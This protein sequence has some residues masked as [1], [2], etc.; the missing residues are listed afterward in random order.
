MTSGKSTNEALL[1]YFSLFV[2]TTD[3][4]GHSLLVDA[5]TGMVYQG[6][7]AQ[8]PNIKSLV[9]TIWLDNN[10][11][12][13]TFF[14][15]WKSV[16]SRSQD[17]VFQLHV[18]QYMSAYTGTPGIVSVDC[19]SFDF[20]S[21]YVHFR[22]VKG[23]SQSQA[24]ERVIAY[25]NSGIALDDVAVRD[26][27]SLLLN[28][29][30]DC[31]QLT[32][33]KEINCLLAIKSG[34]VPKNTE[35][36]LRCIIYSATDSTLLIKS[37]EV[38]DQLKKFDASAWFD[39]YEKR[40][41]LR[42]LAESFNRFKPL[43]L[44]LK[45]PSTAKVIN[46]ISKLS[47][48]LHRPLLAN[49]MN[50]VTTQL[51]STDTIWVKD[52]STFALLRSLDALHR[53]KFHPQYGAYRIRNGK[54]FAKEIV[55]SQKD[56]A[57]LAANYQII[58]H[59]LKSRIGERND[60]VYIPSNVD[61]AVPVSQKSF[62]GNVPSLTR[63]STSELQVGIYWENCM[64]ARDLDLSS[65][66]I[67][68]SKIGWDG[69]YYNDLVA[70]SGDITNA[71]DGAVEYLRFLPGAAS[72]YLVN[73][74]VYS[75]SPTSGYNLI[76][77]DNSMHGDLKS[78]TNYEYMMDPKNLVFSSAQTAYNNSNVLGYVDLSSDKVD[79]VF[80]NM[81][82]GNKITSSFKPE[83]QWLINAMSFNNRHRLSLNC[84]LAELGYRIINNKS[85]SANAIDLSLMELKADTIIS[86]FDKKDFKEAR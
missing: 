85:E 65:I 42:K 51:L 18:L 35:E 84:L 9:K 19:S 38:I 62:V 33:N 53:A 13:K 32:S 40:Y 81:S 8:F 1:F 37:Q 7:S 60:T 21:D 75:G 54:V 83:T 57:I 46:K 34:I 5:D 44:A 78:K 17:E 36:F 16:T 14:P 67:S 80:L 4:S 12:N 82:N 11:L 31:S 58:L 68:G 76:I 63:F 45:R 77:A 26:M 70:F 49:P 25:V 20:E 23:V 56:G 22:F 15:T 10:N 43:I 71:P 74:N 50:C 79:F 39:Q 61:Y 29:G 47:K 41:S 86:L 30:F 59:E 69:R 48:R 6:S 52:A 2:S 73:V 3:A 72:Q 66:N 27:T 64:G 55:S 28:L 24:L